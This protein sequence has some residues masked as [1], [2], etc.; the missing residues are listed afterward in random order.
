MKEQSNGKNPVLAHKCIE[1]S[2][3]VHKNFFKK[4][5]LPINRKR[6]WVSIFITVYIYMYFN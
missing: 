6:Y 5:S 2:E 3:S 4:I 1:Y